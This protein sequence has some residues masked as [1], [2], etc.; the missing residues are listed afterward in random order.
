MTKK[1][2]LNM[3]TYTIYSVSSDRQKDFLLYLKNNGYRW[4][5]GDNIDIEEKLSSEHMATRD[6]LLGKI[7]M[8]CLLA[9][10]KDNIKI[11]NF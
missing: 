2:K 8:Q 6:R 3:A 11:I 9:L 7:S 4:I 1:A 10:K 5:N